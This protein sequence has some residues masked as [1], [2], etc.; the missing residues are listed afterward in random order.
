MFYSIDFLRV[1][2]EGQNVVG[3]GGSK[4]VVRAATSSAS[5]LAAGQSVRV[6]AIERDATVDELLD[7]VAPIELEL[8]LTVPVD[9]SLVEFEVKVV[10]VDVK[11]S[12]QLSGRV[13]VAEAR[14]QQFVG[15][16]TNA[17]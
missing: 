4:R 10:E 8:E 13:R 11:R 12:N 2:V 5:Q 15:D 9:D 3:V 6:V 16:A 1:C 17:G 14:E 7:E